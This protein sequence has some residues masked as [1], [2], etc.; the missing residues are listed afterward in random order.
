MLAVQFPVLATHVERT[1]FSF[2]RCR[3]V[4]MNGWFHVQNAKKNRQLCNFTNG[5]TSE[6]CNSNDL[7]Y[8]FPVWRKSN[9]GFAISIND[10]K[11][12]DIFTSRREVVGRFYLEI[13]IWNVYIKSFKAIVVSI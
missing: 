1:E 10:H 7:L 6:R 9:C 5:P 3:K 12:M 8:K 4:R 2:I 13:S 11:T